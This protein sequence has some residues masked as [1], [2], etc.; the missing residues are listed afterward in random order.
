MYNML[1]YIRS[2]VDKSPIELDR[3]YS[4]YAL[5]NYFSKWKNCIFYIDG[6]SGFNLTDEQHYKFLMTVIP[7]GWQKKLEYPKKV[8]KKQIDIE[9]ICKFYGVKEDIAQQYLIVM[10]ESELK[11]LREVYADVQS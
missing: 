1:D 9:N 3:G 2:I 4:Q 8:D 7:R 5:N 10:D 11:Y 6:I